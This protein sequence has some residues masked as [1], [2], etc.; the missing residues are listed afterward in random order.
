M[1]DNSLEI[2]TLSNNDI[3]YK[4]KTIE[5]DS[6]KMY[7]K[8]IEEIPL[9]TPKQEI[10]LALKVSQGD[11][12]ARI[13]FIES[14]LK[15]VISIANKYIGHG[16]PL[17]DL[18]QEG[19]IGLMTALDKFDVS[20][21]YRF[22]TYAIYWIRQAL[23]SAI[24]EKTRNIKVSK[25]LLIKLRK[26]Q[27]IVYELEIKL[28]RMPT[29]EEVAIAMNKSLKEI[30]ELKKYQ[31]DTISINNKVGVAENTELQDFIQSDDISI[32]DM[33]I[34]KTLLSEIFEKD[35][36]TSTE[37]DILIQLFGLYGRNASPLRVVAEKYHMSGEWVR[38]IR[39]MAL[40]K[41][42]K[43]FGIS[44]NKKICHYKKRKIKTV[45]NSSSNIK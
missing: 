20:K 42:R 30:M 17:L 21:G 16:L 41:I 32:E 14:N 12:E 9:L 33:V 26:Y 19:N 1:K 11:E 37:K 4:A 27:Q 15:L 29:D 18:I 34:S 31:V 3:H 13:K 28:N 45:I 8:D 24:Y 38:N 6:I 2:E 7:I 40:N 44:V 5:S 36:L 39:D 43:E 35:Y 23:I 22:S 25:N 10:E